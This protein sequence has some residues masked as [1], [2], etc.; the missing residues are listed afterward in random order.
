VRWLTVEHLGH[1]VVDDM[2]VIAGEGL[3]KCCRIGATGQRQPG[4]MQSRGPPLRAATQQ[5]DLPVGQLQTEHAAKQV[6]G[7][8]GQ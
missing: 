5:L 2:T 8:A 3:D 1:Q 6:R 4:E 7:F